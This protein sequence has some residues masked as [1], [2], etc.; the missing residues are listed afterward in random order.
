MRPAR[1]R[2]SRR[3][4]PKPTPNSRFLMRLIIAAVGRMRAG[5]ERDLFETYRTRAAQ[6]GRALGLSGPDLVECE[7]PKKAAGE[8]RRAQEA[9]LLLNAAP[10]GAHLVALDERGDTLSSQSIAETLARRRDA[11]APALA[12]LIGGADGHGAEIGERAAARWSFGAATWPHM[13]VRIM[14]AEQLY[15]AAAIL[16]GHPYHR[17]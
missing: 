16:S 8:R 15:R 2:P 9:D 13:L 4:P 12:F 17:S 10:A 11:G 7:A 6:T 3:A 14:L 5:P 1:R